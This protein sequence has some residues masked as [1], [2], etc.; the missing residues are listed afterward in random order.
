MRFERVYGE[1]LA[2][3]AKFKAK[4]GSNAAVLVSDNI[5]MLADHS[6]KFLNA[7]QG[8]QS[9]LQTRDAKSSLRLPRW[10]CASSSVA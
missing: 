10:S 4:H 6:P 5:D 2:A 1:F 3:A 8:R 9:R 7:L